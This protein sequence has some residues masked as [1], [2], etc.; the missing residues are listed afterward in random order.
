MRTSTIILVVFVLFMHHVMSSEKGFYELLGVASTADSREI[1]KAFKKLAI[2]MHPD[3]N[4]DDPEAQEK[5]LKLKQ[6]YEILKDQETRKQY[7]LHGEK[8]VKDGKS[9]K[10]YQTWNFYK[11]Q[12]GI[13]DDDP[14][15]ITLSSAD[16]GTTFPLFFLCLKDDFYFMIIGLQNTLSRTQWNTGSSSFTRL[17]APTV[18][19]WLPVG[20]IWRMN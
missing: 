11:D 12:F 8:G 9:S 5:F 14:E 17:C 16:F 7:D 1:R 10:D 15:I 4:P 6:A 3:K 18:T 13:Y 20:E 2:T 19:L